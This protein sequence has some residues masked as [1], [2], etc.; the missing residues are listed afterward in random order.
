MPKIKSVNAGKLLVKFLFKSIIISALSVI[1]LSSIFAEILYKADLDL[2]FC[3]YIGVF[4]CF[5]SA[6]ITAYFS[7]SKFK[8][9]LIIMAILSVLPICLYSVIN[10]VFFNKAFVYCIASIA[11]AVAAAIIS[12]VLRA[13]K[14]G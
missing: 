14:R 7:I 10:T 1:I 13:K 9:S 8:S 3:P 12:S 6:L 11:L 4:I 5:V 2:K